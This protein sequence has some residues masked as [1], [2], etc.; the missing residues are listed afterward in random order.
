LR[1]TGTLATN[2]LSS[3]PQMAASIERIDRGGPLPPSLYSFP[4]PVFALG[5]RVVGPIRGDRYVRR[6]PVLTGFAVFC[7]GSI[8]CCPRHRP[9][10]RAF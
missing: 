5:Q 8:W 1:Q 4:S 6:W 2:I 9:A 7:A 10:C 3:L